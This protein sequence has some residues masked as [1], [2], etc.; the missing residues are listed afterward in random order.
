MAVTV[1]DTQMRVEEKEWK[2]RGSAGRA[3]R[4][5]EP[6]GAGQLRTVLSSV[7]LMGLTD[8]KKKQNKTKKTK[9]L[10]WLKS[11]DFRITIGL[12]P[13]PETVWRKRN[14]QGSGPLFW[15]FHHAHSNWKGAWPLALLARH[16]L[17][18]PPAALQ[19]STGDHNRYLPH[20]YQP[21]YSLPII[22]QSCSFSSHLGLRKGS[23]KQ[24]GVWK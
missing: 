16:Q 22:Y 4:L 8:S 15:L 17:S 21:S 14:F 9:L 12:H 5:P 24:L 1:R 10:F 2:A 7:P 20:H 23:L 3:Q 6:S 11:Q 19:E 13:P 18:E